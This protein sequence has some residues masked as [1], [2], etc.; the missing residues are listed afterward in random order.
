MTASMNGEAVMMDIETG[1]YYNLGETGGRIWELLDAPMTILQLKETLM[2]EYDV[3]AEQCGEDLEK[4]L[5]VLLSKG[6]LLEA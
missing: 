6:L 2:K 5:G 4:F 1:K 3:T